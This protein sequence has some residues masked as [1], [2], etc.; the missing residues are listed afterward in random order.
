MMENDQLG[1]CT[2]AGM[3]HAE[4]LWSANGGSIDIPSDNDVIT[5]YEA[6]GGY[7]PGNPNTDNGAV[8]LTVL[9]YWKTTGIGGRKIM[10]YADVNPSLTS[11]IQQAIWLFGVGYI[12]VDMPLTA[13]NQVGGIWDV[14]GDGQ[15]GD[16]AP[17]SWGGHCLSPNT[18][19]LTHDLKW[20]ALENIK[21]GQSIIGFDENVGDIRRQYRKTKVL[22]NKELTLPCYDVDFSDGIKIRAAEDHLWLTRENVWTRTDQLTE[23]TKLAKPLVPWETDNS[24][25]AGYLAAAFD[26]VMYSDWQTPLKITFVGN[27]A[28]RALQTTSKTYIAEG[29]AAHNCV[30]IVAYTPDELICVT[31][32]K[33]QRMTY[34]WFNTYCD[35]FHVPLSQDWITAKG[36]AASGFA[37]STLQS[38]LA[39]IV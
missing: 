23:N 7:V 30:D 21:E 11:H 36:V 22:A 4:M 3:G 27:H 39:L 13:Q 34:K 2:C 38:D 33:L 10:G 17:G 5:A 24:R 25:D 31:W 28:V 16:S 6:V 15:S 26:G 20:E 37:L 14:V 35:E 32:G 9:K 1:D 29:F 18:R 19:I 12:G 8:E